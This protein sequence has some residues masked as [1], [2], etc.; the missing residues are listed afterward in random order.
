MQFCA[1]NA[2]LGNDSGGDIS[3]PKLNLNRVC[4]FAQVW[5]EET[6]LPLPVGLNLL[7]K[8]LGI[9]TARRVADACHRSFQWGTEHRDEVMAFARNSAVVSPNNTWA[10]S[11]TM[12]R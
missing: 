11:A 8:K 12:T 3:L 9:E 2:T 7:P 5:Q 1:T 6:G 10:V 4:S